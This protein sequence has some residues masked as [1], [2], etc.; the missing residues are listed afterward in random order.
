VLIAVD[1]LRV[2]WGSGSGTV[3]EGELLG[4]FAGLFK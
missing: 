2:I 3:Y 1:L 4:I